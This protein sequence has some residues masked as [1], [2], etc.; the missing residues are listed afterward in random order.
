MEEQQHPISTQLPHL[1]FYEHQQTNYYLW[2][3]IKF[4]SA[5]LNTKRVNPDYF[6][7]L[8]IRRT[9]NDSNPNAKNYST[10]RPIDKLLPQISNNFASSSTLLYMKII[11]F[12]KVYKQ[13]SIDKYWHIRI[14]T[15]VYY[16]SLC[17]HKVINISFCWRKTTILCLVVDGKYCSNSLCFI[18]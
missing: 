10:L 15:S 1:S 18:W 2:E 17:I 8:V 4:Y 3:N 11:E 16:I 5:V 13:N 12:Y 7:V 6:V 9:G 14:L